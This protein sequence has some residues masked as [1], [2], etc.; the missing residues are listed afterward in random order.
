MMSLKRILL[1]VFGYRSYQPSTAHVVE[2]MN[3]STQIVTRLANEDHSK[4]TAKLLSELREIDNW[5]VSKL[6]EVD[7]TLLNQFEFQ[8]SVYH[9]HY[10]YSF[11]VTSQCLYFG[12]PMS[13]NDQKRV[14]YQMDT[15][16]VQAKKIIRDEKER[17][18]ANYKRLSE[19]EFMRS[20]K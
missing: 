10:D 15:F 20:L 7:K 3:V 6:V 16:F 18:C 14:N 1:K 4:A 5:D 9:K 11:K 12:F 17:Q 13:L 2:H 8:G 19:E